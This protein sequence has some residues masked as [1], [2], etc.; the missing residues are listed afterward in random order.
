MAEQGE[1]LSEREID[2]LNCVVDG[3]ANKEIASELVISE[4]T[5]KVHLRNIYTKL[6]VNSRTEAATTALQQG[7]IVLPGTEERTAPVEP[8]A[9]TA[10]ATAPATEPAMGP[11][12]AAPAPGFRSYWRPLA[13]FA[14]AAVVLVSLLA[15]IDLPRLLAPTAVASPTPFADQAIGD[16]AWSESAPLPTAV[17]GQAVA[18][19]G[20]DIYTIGGQTD[21]GVVNTVQIFDTQAKTWLNAPAKPTAVTDAAAAVLFGEIFVTGGSLAS[22]EPTTIVEAYSP[23]QQAW[24][25]AALMPSPLSGG[26]ALSDGSFLYHAGGWDGSRYRD[27]LLRYDPAADNWEALSPLPTA[28]AFTVGKIVA[29]KLFVIGGEND[30]GPLTTCEQYDLLTNT[31]STCAPLAQPRAGAG[32]A[33]VVNRLY[34]IGGSAGGEI[35]DVADD[36]W[37]PLTI[38]MHEQAN[39]RWQDVGMTNVETS[40]YV[41]GGREQETRLATMF[42][43]TPFIYR[44]YIPATSNQ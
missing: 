31:W 8:E 42:V 26:V 9:E 1:A 5:V 13:I 30:S 25:Q 41:L 20:L 34:V 43:Y 6:G 32:S 10:V 39:G 28:R 12:P 2:V 17:S 3:L 22:G 14:L 36:S 35:Y 7:I 33:L 18:A 40:I 4:N 16:T 23:A 15:F 44:T 19:V 29:G 24:R 21:A 37:Q 38:P 11:P 27:D